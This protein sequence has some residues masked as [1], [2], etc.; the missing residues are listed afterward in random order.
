VVS[1]MLILPYIPY[2][3][4]GMLLYLRYKGAPARWSVE[5]LLGALAV[6]A[7][8]LIDSPTRLI[9]TSIFVGVF[10][11]LVFAKSI[12]QSRPVAVLATIGAVSYPLYLLHEN[13]GWT[14]IHHLEQA[15]THPNVAI[16]LALAVGLLA[17]VALHKGVEQPAMNM[18]RGWYRRRSGAAAAVSLAVRRKWA[19]GTLAVGIAVLVGNRIAMHA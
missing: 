7:I 12:S 3:A 11:L 1:M 16:A 2:F 9:S 14:L 6:C 19:W 17:A 18:I 8:A 15:G 13:I 10:Y 5:G 4:L